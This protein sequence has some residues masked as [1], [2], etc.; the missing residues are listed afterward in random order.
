M[1]G[2]GGGG[3]GDGG[4]DDDYD[5]DDDDD[6]DDDGG[7]S[8]D[9]DNGEDD[10]DIDED[11]VVGVV[12][13]YSDSDFMVVTSGV[14]GSNIISFTLFL[15]VRSS[16]EISESGEQPMCTLS[17]VKFNAKCFVFDSSPPKQ[18][19]S[20]YGCR[21]QKKMFRPSSRIYPSNR[22]HPNEQ[23][24]SAKRVMAANYT[25]KTKH[26]ASYVVTAGL[27]WPSWWE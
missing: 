8:D 14:P 7:G 10:G 23:K 27:L 6:D 22:P 24:G 1:D 20:H 11:D 4:D 13:P 3:G 17:Q 2:C 5:D 9:D 19:C 21:K 25:T 16:F 18:G 12:P 26:Q 15:K